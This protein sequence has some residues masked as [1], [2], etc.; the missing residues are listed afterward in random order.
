[1]GFEGRNAARSAMIAMRNV[2]LD[3]YIDTVRNY[4]MSFAMWE[5]AM[6]MRTSVHRTMWREVSESL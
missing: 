4:V 3:V 2:K 1:M 6:K 5:G